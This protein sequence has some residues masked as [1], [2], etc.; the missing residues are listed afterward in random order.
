MCVYDFLLVGHCDSGPILHRFWDTATYWLK[1]SI[2]PTPS[3]IRRPRSLSSLWNFAV[4]LTM[5]KLESCGY[6]EDRMIVAWVVLTQCQR[7]T[8]RRTDGR[9]YYSQYSALD[10]KLC[11][12]AVK[13]CLLKPAAHVFSFPSYDHIVVQHVHLFKH[14]WRHLLAFRA[15][16]FWHYRR[17]PSKRQLRS[18]HLV[19]NTIDQR[20]E[21]CMLCIINSACKYDM[22]Q[23]AIFNMRA[24]CVI[25]LRSTKI[26]EII[27]KKY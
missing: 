23:Y 19:S 16:L 6:T 22:M 4:K 5:R 26:K 3:L 17:T 12:R 8:D 10:S 1:L 15:G 18:R 21:R 24:H 13:T 27:I 9:I 14:R 2:F 7:V 20:P 11:W 25:S